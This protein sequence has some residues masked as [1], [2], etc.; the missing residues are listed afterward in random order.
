[1]K[2]LF[3]AIFLTTTSL[4][5]FASEIPQISIPQE[6]ASGEFA[7]GTLTQL[8]DAEVAEFLPWAQNAQNQ[9]NRAIKQ[10]Q[11]LPLRERLNH[12]ERAAR[13]VVSRSEGRQYQ[14]FMRFALNRGLLLVDELEKNVDM[15]EI[16]SQE[17]ALDIIQRSIQIALSFYESDLNFQ[18]R[19]QSGDTTTKLSYAGFGA[20][21]MQGMYPGVINVLDATAQYRLLYKL[22]EMVNWDLSRD[23]E[24][25][26][27][28]E[29][30]V[31]AHEMLQDL[32]QIPLN[33][34]RS[35]LRLI[36]RLNS[37]K[38]IEV[39]NQSSTS[40]VVTPP[41]VTQDSEPVVSGHYNGYASFNYGTSARYCYKVDGRGNR[42][43]DAN[44][45]VTMSNCVA[46]VD[47]FAYGT[48]ARYCYNVDKDGN[49]LGDA[50]SAI[51]M[52]QCTA[53]YATFPYGTSA[54]YCYKVDARGNRLGDANSTVSL[55]YCH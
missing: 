21:F 53:G 54:R 30:I 24:A 2:N 22:V 25:A 26:R 37:L 45:M 38:I 19:A 48:S 23:A 6:L 4:I 5:T 41:N 31:E 52:N 1:M 9:L 20:S 42:L 33:D 14:M 3:F 15:E 12:I 28:A 8:T 11:S 18:R 47:S 13:S 50:N 51:D 36:R 32:P 44:S 27:Y 46:G 35:N 16:G 55:D 43:G 34:D 29:H 39:R 49:R 10:S 7:E 17:S 40:V